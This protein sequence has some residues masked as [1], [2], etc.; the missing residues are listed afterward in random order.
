MVQCFF[1]NVDGAFSHPGVDIIL[2]MEVGASENVHTKSRHNQAGEMESLRTSG[3]GCVDL[4]KYR[5]LG[6]TINLHSAV[7]S[8]EDL[9]VE[10]L[11][12]LEGDDA[13]SGPCT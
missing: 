5:K 3:K 1:T 10:E 7:T 11:T 8:L 9:E 13:G 6:L 2:L 12:H 4:P